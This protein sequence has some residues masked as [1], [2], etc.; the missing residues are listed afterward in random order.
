M[1]RGSQV[2][3]DEEESMMRKNRISWMA[4]PM[5]AVL[6]AG[7]CDSDRPLGV[8]ESAT[9]GPGVVTLGTTTTYAVIAGDSV[10]STNATVITGEV[11]VSPGTTVTGFP[12]AT[13]SGTT[14]AGNV[15]AGTAITDLTVAIND[16]VARTTAVLTLPSTELGGEE[17]AP[18][19]Y[20]TAS[21]LTIN[22]TV[23][24]NALG[25]SDAMFIIRTS[26]SLT[27]SSGSRVIL[28]GGAQ[29]SNVIWV[30]GTT[31]TLGANS[32]FQGT[33]LANQS[34]TLLSGANVTGRVLSRTG[35]VTLDASV[36]AVP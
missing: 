1:K 23:T 12:P 18:G 35:S 17:L 24:L 10:V 9:L 15:A 30:V 29:A 2:R 28:T 26:S 31:A 5:L 33:I 19:L 36:V 32:S 13:A 16:V 7:C 22:G 21:P 6:V 27:T 11:G 8:S 4:A 3:L 20:D 34:I 14:N 25:R